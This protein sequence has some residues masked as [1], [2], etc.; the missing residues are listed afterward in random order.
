MRLPFARHP[1]SRTEPG[2]TERTALDPRVHLDLAHLTALEPQG[3][4]L[5]LL[6]R[7]PARSV[8][9]GRHGSHLRGRGL[10]FLE[11][12]DYQ[13]SDDVRNIDWRVTARTGT[14][15]VR[16]FTEER[17][18]P[19]LLVVDQRMS[20]FFGSRHAMKSVTAAEAAALLGFAV[21]EQ[22][23]RVGG[24]VVSDEA[25]EEFRP[26]RSRAQLMR[27]LSALA[28]ANQ[29]LHPQRKAP[30]PT[31]L[32]RV[33]TSVARLASRDHLIILLS[34]FDVPG[35]R[36]EALL[37]AIRRHNDLMLVAVSDPLSER[38]PDDLACVATDGQ[39]HARFDTSDADQR[40]ALESVARERRQQLERWSRQLGV[41]LASLSAGSPT[42]P[43]LRTLLGLPSEGA[44]GSDAGNDRATGGRDE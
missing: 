4:R 25:V 21:L 19:A 22:G 33:L 43:Q 5:R 38:L 27:Y 1:A 14:P 7:Q 2:S 15:H 23:D 20:M 39:R 32:D 44:A 17:D 37:G 8:L 12:R 31:S 24:I 16:V 3:R 29:A 30:A 28:Q 11:L 13:P 6:P 26:R 36:T 41:G 35:P 10:D 42:L 34:D 9:N 18:R 40:R